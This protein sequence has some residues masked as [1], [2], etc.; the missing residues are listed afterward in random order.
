MKNL[1]KILLFVFI[2]SIISFAQNDTYIV[3]K[4]KGK[5][6]LKK[7]NKE[8]KPQDKLSSKD[9]II[10]TTEDAAAALHSPQKGRFTLRATNNAQK[11]KGGFL[12]FVQNALTP[13][14]ERLSSRRAKS[15]SFE[16]SIDTLVNIINVAKYKLTD[17]F[18]VNEKQFFI[19]KSDNKKIK[20]NEK[21]SFDNGYLLIPSKIIPNKLNNINVK[22]T[23]N[24]NGEEKVIKN[25]VLV[26]VK[27]NELKKELNAYIKTLQDD[28]YDNKRIK[29]AVLAFL[30]DFYGKFN[31]VEI[32]EWL[33]LNYNI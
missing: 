32:S 11:Q 4:V 25:M 30:N 21:L 26:K 20:I 22:L 29:E 24:S 5:I 7:N 1:T 19:L 23:Y 31:D 9:E 27:E 14:S 3:L 15:K 10:F 6:L 2:I 13:A 8:L 18:P 16:E 33:K 17:E 28:N 12:A